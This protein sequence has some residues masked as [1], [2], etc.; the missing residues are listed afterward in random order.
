MAGRKQE[1]RDLAGLDPGTRLLNA[2]MVDQDLA[3]RP[4]GQ[5]KEVVLVENAS[6]QPLQ[7]QKQFTNKCGG[8]KGMSC[9]LT[10]HQRG[11]NATQPQKGEL[12]HGISSYLIAQSGLFKQR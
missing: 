5:T 9:P 6:F 12:V 2:R 7:L 8:L 10:P 1:F 3:H 4:G 11:C